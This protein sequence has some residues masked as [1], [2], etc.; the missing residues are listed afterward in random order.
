M[1]TNKVQLGQPFEMQLH[2]IMA[3]CAER[4]GVDRVQFKIIPKDKDVTVHPVPR[5]IAFDTAGFMQHVESG[6]PASYVF[7]TFLPGGSFSE[8]IAGLDGKDQLTGGTYSHGTLY[9][10]RL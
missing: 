5:W 1:I 7:Q 9:L 8:L 6:E 3:L 2:K 10:V 4:C